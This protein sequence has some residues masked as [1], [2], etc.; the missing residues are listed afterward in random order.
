MRKK[1][2]VGK[3]MFLFCSNPSWD[4]CVFSEIFPAHFLDKHRRASEP[5]YKVSKLYPKLLCLQSL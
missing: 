5:S 1:N 3:N 2:S 4:K